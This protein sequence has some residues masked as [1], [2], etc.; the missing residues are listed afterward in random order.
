MIECIYSLVLLVGSLT[1]DFRVED[2]GQSQGFSR[3]A[4]VISGLLLVP[5]S[6]ALGILFGW[7]IYLILQN[8]TTIEYHEGVRAMWIAKN[9]GSVYKHPYDLGAYEN[10]TSVLGPS[11]LSWVCPT[12]RHIGPGLRFRTAYD[13]TAGMSTSE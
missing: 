2:D 3:T 1:V 7:H 13:N 5:L 6:V 11:I 9:G 8:K 12:S 10:L 4:Y